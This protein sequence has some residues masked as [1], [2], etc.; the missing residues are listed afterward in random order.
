[1]IQR[2]TPIIS[3]KAHKLQILS[4]LAQRGLDPREN[5]S[6][7][8]DKA[9]LEQ[10]LGDGALAPQE[11]LAAHLSK[12]TLRGHRG[13]GKDGG[14]EEGLAHRGGEFGVGRG[15]RRRHVDGAGEFGRL[16][17]ELDGLWGG[18]WCLGWVAVE[19]TIDTMSR[20]S[21]PSRQPWTD[22]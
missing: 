15:L 20:A 22:G 14:A 4:L 21:Q 9:R 13:E 16:E 12:Q 10:L 11:H 18:C 6:V 3:S 5:V 8:E 1:M 19:G 2:R 17:E 7:L